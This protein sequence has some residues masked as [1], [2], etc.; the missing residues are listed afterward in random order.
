GDRQGNRVVAVDAVVPFRFG[1]FQRKGGQVAEVNF[2]APFGSDQQIFQLR[3]L[4]QGAVHLNVQGLPRGS[5][6]RSGIA[7]SKGGGQRRLQAGTGE[8]KSLHF[9]DVV[10]DIEL[11]WGR[12]ADLDI[13][14]VGK[15]VEDGLQH[16]LG[17]F[18]DFKGGERAVDAVG[19]YGHLLV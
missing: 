11:Q 17:D 1:L 16:I 10:G 7:A 13:T 9:P 3:D 5:Q 15:S 18:P 2:F 4:L 6:G 14:D 19:Q 8:S 12:T